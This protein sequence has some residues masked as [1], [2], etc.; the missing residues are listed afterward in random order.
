[1][2]GC[3]ILPRLYIETETQ[4]RPHLGGHSVAIHVRGRVFAVSSAAQESGLRPGMSLGQAYAVSPGAERLPYDGDLYQSAQE[5]VLRICAD[6]VP[7]IEPRRLDELFFDL[8]GAGPPSEITAM[9]ADSVQ[10]R[11]GFTCR[12]GAASSKLVARIAALEQPGT[13]VAVGE[14]A[15]FL[16]SLPLSRMWML[17]GDDIA[18]LEALGITT[19]GLLQRVPQARLAQ[20]FGRGA[21]RVSDLAR[22]VDDSPVKPVYPPRV[23]EARFAVADGIGNAEGMDYCLRQLSAEI[24]SRLRERREACCRLSLQVEPEGGRRIARTL[25]LRS[26][27]NRDRDL[28]SGCKLLLSRM[29][30]TGPVT[31]I[32]IQASDL[33]R[34]SAVQ[35]DLFSDLPPR[36][37]EG[38]PERSGCHLNRRR[39]GEVLAAAQERFGSQSVRLGAQLEVPRRERML[40]AV[41]GDG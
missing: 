10:R 41:A 26:P 40:A 36:A 27:A 15:R 17:D 23:I 20:W 5:R 24:A 14:E 37:R 13:V 18:H 1:L 4:R 9:I 34:C 35:H 32:T 7:A 6:Y 22:G 2:L 31:E 30:L 21:R 16:A 19:I 28:L 12:V 29:E 25:R 39:A 33:R 11:A 38:H 8:A 3:L